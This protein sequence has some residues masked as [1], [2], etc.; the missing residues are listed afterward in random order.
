MDKMMK[1][2]AIEKMA[3]SAKGE[4]YDKV[5]AHMATCPNCGYEFEMGGEESEYEDEE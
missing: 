4:K 1:L 5:A 3:K 2:A